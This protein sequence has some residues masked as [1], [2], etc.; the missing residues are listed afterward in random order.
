M[1]SEEKAYVAGVIDGE[2]T[3]TLTRVHKNEMPSPRVSVANNNLRLLKWIKERV[4]SGCIT[5]RS[6][7]QPQHAVHYVLNISDNTALKLL[8]DVKGYL[9]IKRLHAELIVSK[10][11]EA[12]PRNG[13]YTAEQLAK[14]LKLVEEIR[15]LNQ[16]SRKGEVW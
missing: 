14:K 11:K 4:G 13:R 1:T 16:M 6:K 7:Q 2:G 10:Y 5:T 3:V 9:L 12:T 8:E 15:L